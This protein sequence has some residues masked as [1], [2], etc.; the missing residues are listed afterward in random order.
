VLDG[1]R[2]K[3]GERMLPPADLTAAPGTVTLIE[4]PS[5]VGKSSLFAAL[6]GAA[7]FDGDASWGGTDLRTLTPSEWLAWAGQRPGLLTG[8]IADNVT[9]GDAA[10]DPVTVRR[11]LD[12]AC[13]DALDPE[14]ELGA[15][16]AGLSGGQAQRVAV[17]RAFYRHLRGKAPVIALDE[18][19]SALD[20]E[21]EARLWRGIRLLADE[22]ATVLLISHRTSARTIADQVVRLEP[23]EVLA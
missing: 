12:L 3:R 18:P 1:M 22:G 8:S 13:A 17:A 7:A 16:G 14:Q 9:L 6:R 11:A 10:S 4:G 21:T 15:Q 2:V 19:S 20:P 5:G 23:S